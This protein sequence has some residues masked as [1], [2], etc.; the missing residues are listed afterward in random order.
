MNENITIDLANRSEWPVVAA[1]TKAS[2]AE[3]AARTNKNFW[4]VY[5][6]STEQVLLTDESAVRIVARL[7]STIV[8]SVVFYEPYT[9][10]IGNTVLVN[11]FPEMRLLA[12]SPSHRN[13]GIAGDLIR[14]CEQRAEVAGFKAITLHTTALM[15][16]AKAMYERRGYERYPKLDFEPSPGVVVWGFWKQLSP[17]SSSPEGRSKAQSGHSPQSR[18]ISS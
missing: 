8:G 10:R 15:K 13:L 4:D 3:F 18:Q 12:V 16:T 7:D 5:E 1:I 6:Q 11:E 17:G 14:T 9:R 2:Y